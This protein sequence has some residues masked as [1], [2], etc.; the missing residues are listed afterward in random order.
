M[1]GLN[2]M[3][4]N[5]IICFVI[6]A[7]IFFTGCGGCGRR[8]WDNWDGSYAWV[9]EEPYIYMPI[10]MGKVI[11][12]IDGDKWKVET[13]W[14]PDGTKIYFKEKWTTHTK[15]GLIWVADVKLKKDKLYLT[16][17]E[18]HYGE[19]EGKEIVLEQQPVQ[20]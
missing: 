5:S 19:N 9:S 3:K 1:E 14:E 7:A 15:D 12:E 11:I 6:V 8:W 16:I 20:E 10:D 2:N 4:K 18:D 17:I 13:S